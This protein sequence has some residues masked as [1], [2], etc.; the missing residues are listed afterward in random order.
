MSRLLALLA[1]AGCGATADQ[2]QSANNGSILANA[3]VS[4]EV[5]HANTL[6]FAGLAFRDVVTKPLYRDRV[7]SFTE[8]QATAYGGRITG[9]VALDLDSGVYHCHCEAQDVDLGTVLSE[10]GGNNAAVG[11]TLSGWVDLE[12]PIRQ[13]DKMKGRGEINVA[14]G[15]MVQ[16]P[17]LANLLIGDPTSSKGQDSASARFEFSD[18]QIH[19]LVGRLNSPACRIA[20]KG[21]IGFDGDLR[22]YLIPRFKFDLIDQFPGLG[23]VV[24]PLLSSVTSR[25]ARALVRG[26]VT[27][28]VMVINPFLH[29]D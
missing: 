23:P 18:G 10:F 26:Q 12:I 25:V 16:L 4:G 14:K 21:T 17:L 6:E 29:E 15:S 1:L 8:C 24:A 2:D 9:E 7:L 3:T 22:L 5:L 19:V 11:G 13:P 20:I 28:P 27:K